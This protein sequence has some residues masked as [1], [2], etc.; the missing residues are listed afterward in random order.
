MGVLFNAGVGWGGVYT[1]VY[2]SSRDSCNIPQ[3]LWR[4][5]EKHTK[6]TQFLFT[7][8]HPSL[9]PPPLTSLHNTPT[10][11]PLPPTSANPPIPLLP[12]PATQMSD[13]CEVMKN[14]T[15]APG[16]VYSALT[17]NLQGAK[18]AVSSLIQVKCYLQQIIEQ[19][20]ATCSNSQQLGTTFSNLGQL[21]ATWDNLL[22]ISNFDAELCNL[23]QLL[24][25]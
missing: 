3:L 18:S 10:P 2:L 15:K 13:H 17:P 19:F 11:Y 23:R 1:R 4:G 14:V 5:S 25:T 7:H 9:S 24:V 20:G 22:N 21:L 6:A 12:T 8:I 16:V